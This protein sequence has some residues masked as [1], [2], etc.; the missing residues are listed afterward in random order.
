MGKV[1]Y[2]VE[3]AQFSLVES[4]GCAKLIGM[5]G[6]VAI[7]IPAH[8]RADQPF[9]EL[10]AS[11]IWLRLKFMDAVREHAGDAFRTHSRQVKLAH[12]GLQELLQAWV[13]ALLGRGCCQCGSHDA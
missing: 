11:K 4:A 9:A 8:S 12:F 7:P 6:K 5:V 13:L 10:R 1:A 2:L 3:L